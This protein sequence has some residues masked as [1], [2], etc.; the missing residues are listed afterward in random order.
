MILFEPVNAQSTNN[1]YY[2]RDAFEKYLATVQRQRADVEVTRLR[3]FREEAISKLED[4][5][6]RAI[7]LEMGDLAEELSLCIAQFRA[8]IDESDALL[9]EVPVEMVAET[10][11]ADEPETEVEPVLGPGPEVVDEPEV[12]EEPVDIASHLAAMRGS[13]GVGGLGRALMAA[14]SAPTQEGIWPQASSDREPVAPPAT[15][16][17]VSRSAAWAPP[18]P[19]VA[20]AKEPA[21][22]TPV[23]PEPQ[24]TATADEISSLMGRLAQFEGEW[25]T[26]RD[27]RQAGHEGELGAITSIKVRVLACSILQ[28]WAHSLEIGAEPAIR[29]EAQELLDSMQFWLETSN[30]RSDSPCFATSFHPN[31]EWELSA[32]K[33]LRLGEFYHDLVDARTALDYV[34]ASEPKSGGSEIKDLLESISSRQ[35]RLF[36]MLQS[37]KASDWLQGRMYN[38][39]REIASARRIYLSTLEPMTSDENLARNA[40]ALQA[41]LAAAQQRQQ[42]ETNRGQKADRRDRAAQAVVDLANS[43]PDFGAQPRDKTALLIALQECMDCG[44]QPTRREIR[45]ALINVGP[46]LLADQPAFSRF[47]AAVNEQRSKLGLDPQPATSANDDDDDDFEDDDPGPEVQQSQVNNWSEELEPFT[48]GRKIMILGGVRRARVESDLASTLGTKVV[49]H[50]TSTGTSPSRHE[51]EVRKSDILV[52]TAFA[53][54]DL[55][56]QARGWMADDGKDFVMLSGGTGKTAVLR[57]LHEHFIR[58]RQ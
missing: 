21:P 2:S 27:K 50:P 53:G 30:D 51:A 17:S 29:T 25:N 48:K 1:I 56:D 37:S 4:E 39:I 40:E 6:Q 23:R 11:T 19:T 41:R 13:A 26:L 14:V 33:W 5:L 35:Q 57:C 20:I 9:A 10:V 43:R 28:V 7:T 15:F 3:E 22:L 38:Q 8:L 46:A 24:L 55:A 32:A 54:H 12:V 16:L 49:W 44:V 36:R 18:A 52:V 45:D 42:D 47:L 58:S 31:H 34:M